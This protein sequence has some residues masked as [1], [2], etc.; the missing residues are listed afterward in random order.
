[1]L[2]LRYACAASLQ[3]RPN[4]STQLLVA[5]VP[6][7]FGLVPLI[8]QTVTAR[9]QRRD[10][11]TQ[12][13][14]LRA[15]LE[16][17]ERLHTIQEKVGASGEAANGQTTIDINDALSRVL[18]QYNKLAELAPSDVVGSKQRSTQQLSFLRRVF[19]LYDPPTNLGWMLHT[20]F[21][22]LA[23]ILV[24]YSLT[25]AIFFDWG[26]ILE[27]ALLIGIPGSIALLVTQRLAR[28]NAAYNTRQLEESDS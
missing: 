8:V 20:L 23:F 11:M 17:L 22:M 3:Q 14:Q 16:I 10:R 28:H 18:D 24:S 15:E 7:L 21:Y 2:R 6:G 25:A 5:L 4:V 9:A 26:D 1:M 19:L 27:A 13:N 12:L